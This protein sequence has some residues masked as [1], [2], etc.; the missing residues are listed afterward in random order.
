LLER[1]PGE[2]TVTFRSRVT[3]RT[4]SQATT[5]IF[6]SSFSTSLVTTVREPVWYKGRGGVVPACVSQTPL[7]EARPGD[8]GVTDEYK[9]P[10]SPASVVGLLRNIDAIPVVQEVQES[11]KPAS[12]AYVWTRGVWG[13]MCSRCWFG[14]LMDLHT[15]CIFI[16]RFSPSLVTTVRAPVWYKGRGGVVPACVSQTPLVEARPGDFGT[17]LHAGTIRLHISRSVSD[18]SLPLWTSHTTNYH[19]IPNNK[20]S[21]QSPH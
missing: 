6:V 11:T 15:T 19:I 16:S 3:T 18:L 17:M 12:R 8:F 14:D 2:F 21:H 5:C 10:S 9:N 7:V 20:L 1:R 4:T 13:G